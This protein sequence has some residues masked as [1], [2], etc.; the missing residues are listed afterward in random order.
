[1]SLESLYNEVKRDFCGL[2]DYQMLGETIKITVPL[3]TA[4]S[5]FVTVFVTERNNK[6]VA[7][8]GGY[9]LEDLYNTS[10]YTSKNE[11]AQN[12]FEYLVKYYKI[13]QV[14]NILYKTTTE[15]RFLS[16]LVFEVAHFIVNA[17]NSYVIDFKG[18]AEKEDRD[19]FRTETRDGLSQ[20]YG[21][22]FNKSKEILR[23]LKV[24][25]IQINQDLHLL[26]LISGS[27]DNHFNNSVRRATMNF[28]IIQDSKEP[29]VK[30]VKQRLVIVNTNSK[31]YQEDA[32]RNIYSMYLRKTLTHDFV[33]SSQL[34]KI[35]E[36]IPN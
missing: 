13:K 22:S 20:I 32:H 24:P 35:R 30:Y 28:Q 4:T 34:H 29:I 7:A 19:K 12:A 31:A 10:D 1:M 8:D 17:V 25:V 6:L 11:L 2:F 36:Y 9:L 16:A 18:L 33:L 27:T 3:V 14:G 26:E 21:K 15:P 23:G 5:K